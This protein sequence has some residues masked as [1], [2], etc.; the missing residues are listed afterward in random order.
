M[1]SDAVVIVTGAARGIGRAM[2]LGLAG[3]GARIAALDVAASDPAMREM[4]AAA[5]AQGLGDR[6]LP[7]RGDVTNSEECAAAVEATAMH[8][9][10]V[11]GLV[12]NAG[13]G[14]QNI[15]YGS[16]G[17]KFFEVDVGAW[18][19]SFDVNVN[20][21]F[22]MAKAVVPRLV[23]QG[24]GRI[25]NITTSLPTMLMANFCPYGPTKAALEAATAIWSKDLAGTGVCVN[26][27]LP[28]GAV[29]TRMIPSNEVSDRSTLVQ[30]EAMVAPILWL[31]SRDSDG[32]TGQRF[33]AKEWDTDCP[34]D[35]AAR[36]A[37][38]PAG[39]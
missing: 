8:F 15:G 17:K 30:P 19:N 9:G 37:G 24:W 33:I 25:V 35:E 2:A 16:A 5:V 18:R 3:A 20:G 4:I 11:Q 38:S 29:N 23:A 26:A 28:G 39:W 22:I 6:I 31:M 13:L 14:M 36:K 32:V 7:L 21:P 27:L 34:A 10:S 1:S 12:N